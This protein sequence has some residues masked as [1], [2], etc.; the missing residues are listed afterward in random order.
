MTP[1]QRQL[2]RHAL[3]LDRQKDAYRNS[4]VT[5]L[6]CSD[7]AEWLAM[8]AAGEAVRRCGDQLPFGGDDLFHLTRSGAMTA[9]SIGET[10][11]E[12][13]FPKEAA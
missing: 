4:F 6:G 9:L 12:A 13:T 10:L 11:G 7:Y 8:V 5:G 3:G 1:S 2:A